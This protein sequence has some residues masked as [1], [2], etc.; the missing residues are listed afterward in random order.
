M[1]ENSLLSGLSDK[2]AKAI[3]ITRED[4]GTIRTG[5]ATPALIE[6][7]SV[8]V[9]EGTQ[10]LKVMELATITATDN[11]TLVITPFDGLIIEEMLKSL[12][13]SKTGFTSTIDGDVIR[14]TIPPLSEDQRKQYLKFAKVKL[15]H[16]RVMVRQIRHDG[17]NKTKKA[18]EGKEISE[19]VRTRIEKKI[20]ELTDKK[21]NDLDE[22]GD[23]KEKEL[24]SI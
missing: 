12:S 18:C 13:E 15:E 17:M 14:V 10:K 24:L 21:N 6:N 2:M 23:R 3:E 5:R 1:D 8:S 7:I 11:K 9:Y 19:D 22:M 16:G 4:L 20:Q